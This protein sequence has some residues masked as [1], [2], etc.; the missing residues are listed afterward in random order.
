MPKYQHT[1]QLQF[2]DSISWL[3]GNHQFK[4]GTEIMAPMQNNYV[5]IPATRGDMS[6]NNNMFTGSG[7]ADFL[8]GYATSVQL[9]NFHEAHQRQHAYSFYLQDDWRASDRLTFNLG[10]RYD[11]MAPQTDAENRVANF[12]LATGQLIYATDG[13][14]EQ[15]AL[16]K[17]DRNNFGPRLG[18][19]YK[20]NTST[21]VRGGYGIYYNLVERI[22]S[23][24]QLVLNPPGLRNI[25]ITAP[26]GSTTPALILRNGFPPNFLDASNINYRSLLLRTA[27]LDGENSMFHQFA[28]GMERQL[29]ASFVA[30]A[31]AIAS[32]GRNITLLRNLN[33]PAN[34]NGAR[35][36]PNFGHIQYR[37]HDGKSRYRGVDLSLEKRFSRGHS[38]RVSYT[39]GDQRDNTPEHL[40]AASPRPQNTSDLD[41]W[42]A[43]G[44]NDIRHRFVGSFIANLPL[45]QHPIARDWLV[46]G[47]LTTHTGRP[48][49]VSQ[50]SLEGAGWVPNRVAETDGQKT[51]DNWFNASDFQ[52]V[53]AGAFGN[54]GRNGLRGPG[55]MTF[56][57]SLQRR[58]AFTDALAATLR[59]DVFNL[60]N[61]T[62][63]GNPNADITAGNRATIT[64]LAGDSR[65]IQFS[66]RLEF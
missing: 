50:G 20:A 7:M 63:F 26:G 54:A 61:R 29:S 56:D 59:F 43:P 13:S 8:L 41:A 34:G 18:I 55:W 66:A 47:I 49:T 53:P 30:S 36:Y 44:D 3:R 23:E 21:V 22:G 52:V 10:L 12:D 6:F 11:F 27:Q 51:V 17:P 58:V 57:L 4:F 65:S 32:V 2:I 62:N 5:D 33:Q 24:D 64:S 42:E 60:T 9:S 16:V 15:R 48:F 37:D 40:S 25:S 28:M 19:V 38:Y 31:D 46:A 1:D 35:P 14:L 45:G 39:I